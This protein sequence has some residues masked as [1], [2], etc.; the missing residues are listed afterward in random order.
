[1]EKEVKADSQV[2][3]HDDKEVG[4]RIKLLLEELGVLDCLLSRMDRTG[5]DND[6]K[7]VIGTRENSGSIEASR[8]N[9]SLRDLRG[10][11]LVSKKSRLNEGVIL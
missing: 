8:G 1:M 10:R 3:T 6:E 2:G 11:N 4:P 7:T 5:A 9:G